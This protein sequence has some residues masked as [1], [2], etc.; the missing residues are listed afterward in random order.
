MTGE[1]TSPAAGKSFRINSNSC[2]FVRADGKISPVR[3]LCSSVSWL[4]AL[5]RQAR[6]TGLVHDLRFTSST[7]TVRASSRRS[8]N[9]TV[10]QDHGRMFLV[11]A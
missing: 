11:S 9:P 8:T 5:D 7:R 10:T 6:R 4:I 3:K 2:S 1:A